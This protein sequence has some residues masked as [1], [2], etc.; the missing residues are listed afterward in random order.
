MSAIIG[1]KKEMTQIFDKKGQQIPCTVI[2]VSDVVLADIKRSERDGYDAFVLGKDKKKRPTKAETGKFKELGFVPKYC[3]EF[4]LKKEDAKKLEGKKVG[5]NVSVDVFEVGDRLKVSGKNKGKGF[6]GVVKRWRFKGGPRTRGQSD[7][8]RAGGSIG[9]GTDP[10]RVLKGKK[11]PGH[12]GDVKKTILN[13][14][15][16]KVDKKDSIMFI[17]GAVPGSRNSILKIYK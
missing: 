13:L 1:V 7:R 3:F 11:M 4:R 5:D 14:E 15:L 9:A 17:R 10:G 6:Q 8:Q 2:D 12:M 16:A